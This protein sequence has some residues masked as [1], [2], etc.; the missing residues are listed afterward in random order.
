MTKQ[1]TQENCF[2]NHSINYFNKKEL[3]KINNIHDRLVH[4]FILTKT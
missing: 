1:K 4:T 3:L 2:K